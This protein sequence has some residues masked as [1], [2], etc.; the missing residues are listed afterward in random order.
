MYRT[1]TRDLTRGKLL[2]QMIFYMLPLVASGVVQML[3]SAADLAVLRQMSGDLSAIAALSAVSTV[4]S[5]LINSVNGLSHGAVILTAQA[6]GKGDRARVRTLVSTAVVT[7][8]ALGAGIAALA[9][10]FRDFLP[11]MVACPASCY[12]DASLYLTIYFLAAPAILLYNFTAAVLRAAGDSRTPA[13][14]ILLAGVV[15]VGLNYLFCLLFAQKVIAVA[16]ATLI[17]QVIGAALCLFFLCRLGEEYRPTL[18]GGHVSLSTFGAILR[19]GLP[20]AFGSAI[21]SLANLPVSGAINSFGE[22]TIAGNGAS[23]QIENF[24]SVITTAF[25]SASVT[26]VARNYGAGNM[27]RAR[28]AVRC[29]VWLSSAVLLLLSGVL[30]LFR[31]P[32]LSLFIAGEGGEEALRVGELRLFT[33][34]AMF[35]VNGPKSVFENATHAVGHTL[36]GTLN[37]L[38]SVM[39]FRYLWVAF[40]FP[41]YPTIGNIYLLYLIS[42]GLTLAVTTVNYFVFG[43]RAGLFCPAEA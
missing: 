1:A 4:I 23:I 13:L 17:S 41:A 10:L 33:V 12:A 21:F 29:G 6:I 22:A 43:R 40:V 34:G 37:N 42:W 7:A 24:L 9:V 5:L 31:V 28:R 30:L 8:L 14:V 26:F 39:A 11:A 25:G 20:C 36:P 16:L 38:F 2:P 27:A 18:R 15:N 3:F 19:V 35:F 32:L